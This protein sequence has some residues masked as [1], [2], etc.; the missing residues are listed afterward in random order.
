MSCKERTWSRWRS[1]ENCPQLSGSY[2]GIHIENREGDKY[3]CKVLEMLKKKKVVFMQPCPE[4]V[5]D[6]ERDQGKWTLL[7]NVNQ[8][9]KPTTILAVR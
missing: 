6:Q 1:K 7:R 5:E 4:V 3:H 8:A 9:L 2:G